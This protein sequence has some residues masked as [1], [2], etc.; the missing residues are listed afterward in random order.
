ME[1]HA[2]SSSIASPSYGRNTRT[3]VPFNPLAINRARSFVI[4]K[5]EDQDEL[6]D[7][8]ISSFREEIHCRAYYFA[9]LPEG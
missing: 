7:E 3:P 4:M 9:L 2:F 1:L 5:K 8:L 6:L